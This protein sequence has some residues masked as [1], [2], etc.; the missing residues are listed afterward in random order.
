MNVTSIISNSVDFLKQLQSK[1][2]LQKITNN[3]PNI[4][5]PIDIFLSTPDEDHELYDFGFESFEAAEKGE[6]STEE[7]ESI[8]GK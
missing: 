2:E 4:K 6:I 5:R 8:L 7:Y 1:I 3:E